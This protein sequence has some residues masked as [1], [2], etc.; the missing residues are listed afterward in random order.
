MEEHNNNLENFE[1]YAK[2]LIAEGLYDEDLRPIKCECGCED[3]KLTNIY[4]GE[5]YIEEYQLQCTNEDC[6]N[7][8]GNWSFGHWHLG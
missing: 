7:T 1:D 4:Y 8:V 3:F 6:L 5:G 2:R